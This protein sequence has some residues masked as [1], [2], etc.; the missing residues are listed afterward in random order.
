MSAISVAVAITLLAPIENTIPADTTFNTKHP[1]AS[2]DV[3]IILSIKSNAAFKLY[4]VKIKLDSR[5]IP[6]P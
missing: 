5:N 1:N 6:S 3:F 4:I 2:G